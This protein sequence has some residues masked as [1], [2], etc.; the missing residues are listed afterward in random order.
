LDKRD[1]EKLSKDVLVRAE[2]ENN[3]LKISAAYPSPFPYRQV[4]IR[5]QL[6][7]PEGMVLD[8]RNQQGNITIARV[9]KNIFIDQENGDVLLESIPSSVQ[10]EI[11]R[12]NL[13]IKN[14]SEKLAITANQSDMLLENI[15]SL[16]LVS[17]NGDCVIKKIKGHGYIEHTY[18]ELNLD[19]AGQLE[20]KG[21][22]SKMTV[23]NV[24]DGI[25]LSNSFENIFL[26]N[27]AGDVKLSCRLSKIDIRH[28]IAKNTVI[29]NSFANVD[30]TDYSGEVFNFLIKNGNLNLQLK[31]ITESMNIESRNA[32]INLML[33]ALTDPTFSIK[34][35]QGRIYNKL[36]LAMDMYQENVESFATRSGQKPEIIINNIYGDIILQ[37]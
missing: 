23:R 9:G 29:E 35:R 16:R 21:R 25:S 12:G 26:E 11:R 14:V 13:D 34:T 27:I 5:F 17:R 33:G 2:S 1:V 30:L 10:V 28:G 8:V 6:L 32:K 7:V 36:S 3:E 24:T 18:G 20:I 37:H 31:Q 4:R 19:G 15:S 22:H